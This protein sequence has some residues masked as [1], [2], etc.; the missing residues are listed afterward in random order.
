M[1]NWHAIHLHISIG[2]FHIF[3]QYFTTLSSPSDYEL[4]ED[5]G[6]AAVIS[7]DPR[8]NYHLPRSTDSPNAKQVHVS[9]SFLNE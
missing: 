4:P 3:L 6:S 5:K 8:G 9:L 7:E 2:L 1:G